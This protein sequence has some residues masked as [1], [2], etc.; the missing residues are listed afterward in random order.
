MTRRRAMTATRGRDD[1][2]TVRLAG[3]S[4]VTG[5][6]PSAGER[7]DEH[8]RPDER[9][10]DADVDLLGAGHHASDHVG[11]GEQGGADDGRAG[12][13]PAV[14]QADSSRHRCGTTSPTKAIGPATAV[15]APHSMTAPAR[16]HQ[17]GRRDVLAEAG[18]ISS[19]SANA[20]GCG[21]DRQTTA[22]TSRKGDT[23]RCRRTTLPP[24]RRPARNGTVHDVDARQQDRAD[25]RAESGRAGGP[26]QGQLRGVAPPR[27]SEPTA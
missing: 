13:E 18:A 27:P 12:Q 22:P 15:A 11:G 19:P 17:P 3:Q 25:Q 6:A 7:C 16:G 10:D 20:S 26:G 14:V 5:P 2:S 8:R 4:C 1:R 23:S 24:P 9:G 21:R